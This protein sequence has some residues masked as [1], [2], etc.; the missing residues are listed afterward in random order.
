MMSPPP[1]WTD[2]LTLKDEARG[3]Q[4][5]QADNGPVL[6]MVHQWT[7]CYWGPHSPW[8]VGRG[9]GRGTRGRFIQLKNQG[10][11][12]TQHLMAEKM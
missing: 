3:S 2:Q 8:Q 10:L 9:G 4:T 6:A 11:L 7:G 12:E 5:D 1:I